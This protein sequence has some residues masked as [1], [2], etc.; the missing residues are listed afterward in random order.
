M[1]IDRVLGRRQL[2]CSRDERQAP[3]LGE[4]VTSHCRHPMRERDARL[5][6]APQLPRVVAYDGVQQRQ[7]GQV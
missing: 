6:D 5:L 4:P 7:V 2:V 3:L 1:P